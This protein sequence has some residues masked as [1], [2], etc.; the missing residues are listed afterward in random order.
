MK[1][2]LSC[3]TPSKGTR[4]TACRLAKDRTRVRPGYRTAY[5]DPAYIQAKGALRGAPCWM[6]GAPS[7]TVDHLTP[8]AAG[9]T[10]HPSNLAPACRTCNSSRGATHAIHPRA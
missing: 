1:P 8:L 6:C 9:G 4:C 2:C 5:R 7:D 3:G 10:N